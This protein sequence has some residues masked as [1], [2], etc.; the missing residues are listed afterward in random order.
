MTL[1]ETTSV[2]NVQNI[3]VTQK[4]PFPVCGLPL[5]A[6][7]APGSVYLLSLPEIGPHFL[8]SLEV[9]LDSPYSGVWLSLRFIHVAAHI[10]GPS[11]F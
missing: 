9:K 2:I 1:C 5:H 3:S 7:P 10:I 8:D 4:F 11:F 6:L